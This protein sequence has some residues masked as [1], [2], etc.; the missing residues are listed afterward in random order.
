MIIGGDKEVKLMPPYSMDFRERVVAL[1][2]E[3]M[4]TG[5]IAEMMRCS[6]AWVRRLMQRRRERGTIA[7]IQQRHPDQRAYKDE[8]ETKI[9]RF[10]Q[11]HPDATLREVAEAIGKPAHVATVCRTLQ[12]LKLPRKKSPRTPRSRTA[13]TLPRRGASGSISSLT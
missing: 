5:E 3:G 7:P 4:L 2:D 11:E 8:D 13:P 1:H 12:R 6:P 10:I 9:R